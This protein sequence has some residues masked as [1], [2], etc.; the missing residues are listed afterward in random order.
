MV[1]TFPP[2]GRDGRPGGEN[3]P[4]FVAP[5]DIS[6][7][8]ADIE[9]LRRERTAVAR[10]ARLERLLLT[11]R[12]QR[13]GVSG[14]MVLALLVVVGFIGAMLTLVSPR[15]TSAA[16]GPGPLARPTAPAGRIGGLLPAVNLV[17]RGQPVSTAALR[18]SLLVLV[19][20]ECACDAS[21]RE[22]S[23]QAAELS[24]QVAYVGRSAASPVVQRYA[25]TEP[26]VSLALVDTAGRLGTTYGLRAN[27]LTLVFVRADGVVNDIRHGFRIGDRLETQ[28]GLVTP[29]PLAS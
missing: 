18:P 25:A 19:P 8:E 24:V 17:S 15:G 1:S 2:E 29:Q 10:R 9:A 23:R 28:I 6:G 13:H 21:A 20:V 14:P 3:P 11:R 22:I 27:Q 4:S 5:D 16:P 7:L 26:A 12:W